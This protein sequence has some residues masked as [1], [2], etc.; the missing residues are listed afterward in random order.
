[1]PKLCQFFPV[2]S[3]T[4]VEPIADQHHKNAVTSLNPDKV[5]SL[6]LQSTAFLAANAFE[7]LQW[8]VNPVGMVKEWSECVDPSVFKIIGSWLGNIHIGI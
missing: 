3:S 8:L 4:D 6:R 7:I 5:P 1:M 2:N